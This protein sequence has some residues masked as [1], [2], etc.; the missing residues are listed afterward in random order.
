M[1][2]H[3]ALIEWASE[4]GEAPEMIAGHDL[5]AILAKIVTTLRNAL[6]E[7]DWAYA[8]DPKFLA[9]HPYPDVTDPAAVQ[10]WLED[11]RE[12]TTAPWIELYRW[13]ETKVATSADNFALR[14]AYRDGPLPRPYPQAG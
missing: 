14:L 4:S 11:M 3:A 6:P 9:E 1:T 13:D 7:E 8:D 10:Q 2:M 12:A 5:D